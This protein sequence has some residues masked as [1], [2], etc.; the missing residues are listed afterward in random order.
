MC[1][2]A[3]IISP[4]SKEDKGQRIESMMGSIVHRGPDDGQ[5]HVDDHIG[6]GFRRLAIIDIDS[7][8]QPMRSGDGRHWMVFNGEIYNFKSLRETLKAKGHNFKTESDSEVLLNAYKEWGKDCLKHLNG[9]FGF[10]IW[11]TEQKSLFV[12]VDRLGIKPLYYY[13]K[14]DTLVFA[15]EA[16]ALFASGL[17]PCEA[18]YNTLPFHM[19][20]LTAP[21][22]RTMFKNVH[23]LEPGHFLEMKGDDLSLHK[24]WD[25]VPSEDPEKWS[26]NSAERV[27]EEVQ[28]AVIGQSISD[29]PLGSFLSGGVDSSAVCHFLNDHQDGQ[30]ET[31][32][33]G[34]KNEDLKADVLMDERPYAKEMADRLGS[35]HHEIDITSDGLET[36]LPKLVWHMDEP[37][38]D[39]AAITT[40]LV[41]RAARETLTVL[42]SGV[43]GDEL[44]AGYPRHLAIKLM[45]SFRKLPRPLQALA[46]RTGDLIPGGSHSVLRSAKK[47]LRSVKGDE[48]SSYLQMLTYFSPEQHKTLFTQ[49]FY[50]AYCR[51]DVY[52]YHRDY[53][54]RCEGQPLLNK[55]QYVDAKT[56][57]PCLNLTYTDRMS[58]AASIEVRVPLIDDHLF[59][60]LWDLPVDQK[61]YK[62]QRKHI[63]KK[64]M[65]PHLPHDIIWRKKSGFG[66]P[67][68]S[69]VN[70]ELKHLVDEFLGRDHLKKQGIFNPDTIAKLLKSEEK[71]EDYFANHIWQLL[72]FQIWHRIYIENDGLSPTL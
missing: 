9:M 18:D 57:L 66:A 20:F 11:D 5:Y 52:R 7:G 36:L 15:S 34:F 19:T 68:Q 63:F 51:E 48:L 12:A 27:A 58:M 43:G 14:G 40:F 64:A 56:F 21:F 17:V 45:A 6:F 26:E 25:C 67:I 28:K 39:P 31:Y 37:V 53:F 46:T 4:L 62:R 2:I 71:K 55:V 29:V 69:W 35:K 8:A 33:I 3:G 38:G 49:E 72:V 13:K 60:N 41:S 65:E 24:Y 30:L 44:F 54:D 10:A 16:K 1:G 47:F 23:K 22:P 50:D 42:L 61:I 70:N 59:A 32:F